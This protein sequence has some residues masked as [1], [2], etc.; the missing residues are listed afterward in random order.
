LGITKKK[1]GCGC[2]LN[3]NTKTTILEGVQNRFSCDILWASQENNSKNKICINLY[4]P[5]YTKEKYCSCKK[6]LSELQRRCSYICPWL[7]FS[8]FVFLF[9]KSLQMNLIGTTMWLKV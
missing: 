2:A 8:S 3:L 9:Q 6:I 1:V 7:P 4:T 5:A